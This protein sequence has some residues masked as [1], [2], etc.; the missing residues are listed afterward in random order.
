MGLWRFPG[1][2]GGFK[3]RKQ[4]T[5]PAA[6]VGS[7]GVT[8]A[9]CWLYANPL[10]GINLETGQSFLITGPDGTTV[11]PSV[12]ILG[13]S[14]TSSIGRWF[15]ASL[16]SAVANMGYLY[17]GNASAPDTDDA[18]VCSSKFAGFWP[19]CYDFDDVTVN[20]NHGTNSGASLSAGGQV[21]AAAD[22]ELTESD[23]VALPVGSPYTLNT[24]KVTL[25]CWVQAESLPVGNN[26]HI[27]SRRNTVAGTAAIYYDFTTGKWIGQVRLSGST[28]TTRLG[29]S[30][31]AATTDWTLLV[32][33]NDNVE[34]ILYVNGVAQTTKDTTAGAIDTASF[35]DFFL[36]KHPTSG[37]AFYDGLLGPVAVL[38]DAWTPAEVTTFYNATYSPAAFISAWGA[39][40]IAQEA[41]LDTIGLGLDRSLDSVGLG[42]FG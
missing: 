6:Q 24:G 40:Q 37:T 36:G 33:T 8:D 30:N 2:A 23:Y 14:G 35:T 4:F 3:Y 32:L 31:A 9:L 22:F 42:V 21:V 13:G 27:M 15:K 1:I 25:A 41:P 28:G 20:G 19:L 7:G 5:I 38:N 16:S 10:S 26:M 18:A 29:S 17:W 11:W 12:G 34:T 39:L